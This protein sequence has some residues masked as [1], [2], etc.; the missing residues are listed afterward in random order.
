MNRSED[1]DTPKFDVELD[2]AEIGFVLDKHQYRDVISMIDMYHFYLRNQQVS[3][4]YTRSLFRTH[5]FYSIVKLDQVKSKWQRQKQ[6]L[7]GNSHR[8]PS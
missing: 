6:E 7:C 3:Y 5:T 2:F 4:S 8:K 1:K